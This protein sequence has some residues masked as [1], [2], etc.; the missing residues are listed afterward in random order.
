MSNFRFCSICNS[1]HILI[2][3][4]LSRFVVFFERTI[5]GAK[6][7]IDLQVKSWRLTWSF[8]VFCRWNAIKREKAK[9]SKQYPYLVPRSYANL[10]EKS[11][12]EFFKNFGGNKVKCQVLRSGSNWSIGS[13]RVEKSIYE[14]TLE[15]IQK[16]EHYIYIE[17]QFFITNSD[18]KESLPGQ[19]EEIKNKIGAALVQKVVEA[20]R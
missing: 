1:A 6:I 12:K 18:S 5:L 7:Q 16:A 4:I 14:A 15:A 20:H 9:F 11:R 10:Q 3:S 19:F 17:N 8:D 13:N 2:F